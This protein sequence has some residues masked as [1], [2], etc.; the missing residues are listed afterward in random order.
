[1]IDIAIGKDSVVR[2]DAAAKKMKVTPLAQLTGKDGLTTQTG[3]IVVRSADA[4]Q[5]SRTC[6]GYRIL[7]GTAECDE[8]FAA[9]RSAARSAG[10]ELPAAEKP[11]K[12]PQ[13]CSDGAC[14]IIEWGDNETGRRGDL[15]L[16]RAA[17]G[18]LRH[19]QEGRPA[20]RRRDRAGAVHHG[21]CHRSRR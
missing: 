4:A 11:P 21:V 20:G 19:D 5:E 6:S 7:F 15:Q 14:K 18:R 9:P 13:S 8:K 2:H 3:L 16:R 17:V 1:M 10:V 12:R